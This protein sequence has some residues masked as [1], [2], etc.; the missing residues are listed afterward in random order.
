MY[1]RYERMNYNLFVD[2]SEWF[3]QIICK[4]HILIY[5]LIFRN[6]NYPLFILPSYSSEE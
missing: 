1:E 4:E 2:V 5:L 3:F 6:Y